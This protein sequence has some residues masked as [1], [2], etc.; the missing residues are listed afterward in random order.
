MNFNSLINSRHREQVV[1]DLLNLGG[2]VQQDF[3]SIPNSENTMTV[4]STGDFEYGGTFTMPTSNPSAVYG[5]IGKNTKGAS[6]P[7]RYGIFV[8]NDVLT[9]IGEIS[10]ITVSNFISNYGGLTIDLCVRYRD[11]GGNSIVEL[12]INGVVIGTSTSASS[13]RPTAG[14]SPF[15]VGAYANTNG[16]I[17][18]S[19]Y[20]QGKV[21]S[22]YFGDEVWD[23]TEG[24]GFNT[25]SDLGTT[26][27]G[28]T[29]NSGGLSYW[30][31]TVWD[32]E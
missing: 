18:T 6:V 10:L 23:L 26:A 12:C 2:N 27:F 7:S 25:F 31:S 15:L 30:N 9:V 24:N 28:Q 22:F 3:L 1:K 14:T 16:S 17:D 21:H 20:F 19:R 4:P 13:L 11:S 32:S 8:N 5:I 29:S